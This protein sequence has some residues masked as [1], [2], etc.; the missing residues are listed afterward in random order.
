MNPRRVILAAAVCLTAS[1]L[2]RADSVLKTAGPPTIGD[3]TAISR[4]EV[5]VQQKTTSVKVPVNQIATNVFSGEPAR[6]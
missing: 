1:T 6:V 2:A 5:T 4:E 3:V